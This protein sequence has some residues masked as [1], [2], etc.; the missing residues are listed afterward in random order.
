MVRKAIRSPDGFFIFLG[1]RRGGI[2]VEL[3]AVKSEMKSHWPVILSVLMAV[4]FTSC[5]IIGDIFK[6]GMY[7]GIFLVV[8]FIVLVFYLIN[9]MRR[10]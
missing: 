5:E 7:W 8:A 2:V 4:L 1:K 3:S 6:A 10:K 9:K